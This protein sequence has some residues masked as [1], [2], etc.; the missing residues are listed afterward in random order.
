MKIDKS[1]LDAL[2]TVI[3]CQ[4]M[5]N[6]EDD[7]F[8]DLLNTMAYRELWNDKIDQY[9]GESILNVLNAYIK[10]KSGNISDDEYMCSN[11]RLK[12][13]EEK[14]QSYKPD[15]DSIL[16]ESKNEAFQYLPSYFNY[17]DPTIALAIL[18]NEQ[19]FAWSLDS[20]IV[21]NYSNFLEYNEFN[22]KIMAH[23]LHHYY[24]NQIASFSD[25]IFSGSTMGNILFFVVQMAN[26][27]IA[28][29]LSMPFVLE[30]P[31][32]TGKNGYKIVEEFKA[33]KQHLKNFIFILNTYNGNLE[34]L[35]YEL[36]NL[37]CNG[38]V[39][40]LLGYYIANKINS[41]YG[42]EILFKIIE[43]PLTLFDHYNKSVISSSE[44]KSFLVRDDFLT[45]LE[46]NYL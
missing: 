33:I 25:D 29:L 15:I 35:Q 2:Y 37:R 32:K 10:F 5:I 39:F 20:C 22:Q 14:Y 36:Q 45:L 9:S 34:I 28:E 41:I 19:E 43:N 31:E 11:N 1:S 26:E 46:K 30:F 17:E 6:Y 8:I 44:D 3:L 12:I 38:F 16:S 27:G 18:F 42:K 23:E 21:A 40:H 13:F 7:I 24:A 4:D